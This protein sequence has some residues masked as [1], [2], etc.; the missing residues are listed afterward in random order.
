MSPQEVRAEAA[1]HQNPPAAGL[2]KAGSAHVLSAGPSP[3]A[4]PPA[5][6]GTSAAQG[7][8]VLTQKGH[9]SSTGAEVAQACQTAFGPGLQAYSMQ[10]ACH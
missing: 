9:A 3:A 4:R 1:L 5:S 8:S 2:H 7:I 10:R 6:L